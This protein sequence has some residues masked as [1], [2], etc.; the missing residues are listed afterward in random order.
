MFKFAIKKTLDCY[1]DE[2]ITPSE[3]ARIK[4]RLSIK[5]SVDL[6]ALGFSISLVIASALQL[7][8]EFVSRIDYSWLSA[9]KA[10]A[11][12]SAL[13][14]LVGVLGC[15]TIVSVVI[16][17]YMKGLNCVIVDDIKY[18]KENEFREVERIYLCDAELTR[19]LEKSKQ[20]LV[21]FHKIQKSGRPFMMFEEKILL[22]LGAVGS[23]SNPSHR[24]IK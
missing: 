13:T 15:F 9:A 5:D 7:V 12:N 14:L 23:S 17:Q 11:F 10:L 1:I 24:Q 19:N 6:W 2:P 4:R 8:S 16:A 3:Y 18:E 21:L 22:R 20:A